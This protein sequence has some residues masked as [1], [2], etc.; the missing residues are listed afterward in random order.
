LGA[1]GE[2]IAFMRPTHIPV[3][4]ALCLCAACSQSTNKGPQLVSSAGQPAYAVKYSAQLTEA[5]KDLGDAQAEEKTLAQ[6]FAGRLD[7]LKKPDWDKVLVVVEDSDQ[8]GRS[9][10]YADAHEEI[11]AV[12]GFWADEKDTFTQ[13]VGGN[14]QYTVKQAGCTAEV[15]G[16]VAFSLNDTMD[17]EL[18]KR[19]RSKNDA[20]TV[21]ER[22]RAT[23]G[24]QNAAALEKLA[25]DVAQASY[26]VHVV[27]ILAREKLRRMSADRDA[28]KQ[29]L[30]RF[31]QEEKMYQGQPGRTADE[32]KTSEDR[33]NA[34]LEGKAKIDGAA[35]Q[36]D[37]A[38]KDVDPKIDAATK[39]YDDALKA[40]KGKIADKK[41]SGA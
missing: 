20:F 4:A 36:A 5:T 30:D 9:A 41:K 7:E 17:K 15:G 18:Q 35:V 16:A 13:K 11:D 3:A 22:Q 32:K 29:T 23:L 38:M 40:L 26:D 37:A 6:G 14:A 31:V 33:V 34:A 28:V 27:M 25:D 2:I 10:D 1:H 24:Q 39:D 12:R 8:A 21:I 19:L